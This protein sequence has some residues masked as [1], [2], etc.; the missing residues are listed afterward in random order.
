MNRLKITWDVLL[1]GLEK[2]WLKPKGAVKIINEYSIELGCDE[3]LL[4]E[5]NVNEDDK[6]ATIRL[7]K[8]RSNLKDSHAVKY[9]QQRALLSIEQSNKPIIEKLKDIEFQWARFDYPEEWRDF[10]YYIPNARANS[11]EGIYQIFLDYLKNVY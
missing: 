9:W 6:D 7:L 4:I 1:T 2:G 3:E 11:K 5:L 10:I 8:Q